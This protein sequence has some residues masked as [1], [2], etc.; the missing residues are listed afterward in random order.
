VRDGRQELDEL[1]D[2]IDVVDSRVD[3]L[4]SR[5][6]DVGTSVA[7]GGP[8]AQEERAVRTARARLAARQARELRES[9]AGIRVNAR[10][11][12]QVARE[13]GVRTDA[14]PAGAPPADPHRVGS[15]ERAAWAAVEEAGAILARARPDDAVRVLASIREALHAA[16]PAA[17]WRAIVARDTGGHLV[18]EEGDRELAEL[19]A[20]EREDGDGPVTAALAP[21]SGGEDT[22]R[23]SCAAVPG[24]GGL[25][26]LR[27]PATLHDDPAWW[28]VGLVLAAPEADAFDRSARAV[29]RAVAVQV[30]LL[31][32]GARRA[33][34]LHQALET[35]DLI[36]QAKGIVMWRDGVDAETAFRKLVD[37][38]QHTNLKLHAVAQ[39]LVDESVGR[40][41]AGGQARN[42][43]LGEQ[44]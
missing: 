25:L 34:G 38:S 2:L 23:E 21:A 37:A 19:V 36:G 40:A 44:P 22:A 41:A 27:L 4:E 3:A 39:W 35:R 14:P 10:R 43:S 31:L 9:L 26:V 32:V 12:A 6:T 28:P 42:V 16:V 30:E 17:R 1:L 7:G 24:V 15:A 29:G 33:R 5:G 8:D 20:A 13:A 18:V 11:M